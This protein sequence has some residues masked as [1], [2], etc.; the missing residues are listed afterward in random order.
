MRSL[1]FAELKDDSDYTYYG[2]DVI[3]YLCLNAFSMEWEQCGVFTDSVYAYACESRHDSAQGPSYRRLLASPKITKVSPSHGLPGTVLTVSGQY[4]D[5]GLSMN[6]GASVNRSSGDLATSLEVTLGG[7]PCSVASANS[8][9]FTCRLTALSGSSTPISGNPRGSGVVPVRVS[10]KGFGWAGPSLLPLFTVQHQLFNVTPAAGSLGGGQNITIRGVNLP[11]NL[12][13]FEVALTVTANHTNGTQLRRSS[14]CAALVAAQDGTKVVCTTSAL[15]AD[16]MLAYGESEDLLKRY[17]LGHGRNASFDNQ[18]TYEASLDLGV[19]L[20]MDGDLLRCSY[21][22]LFRAC[23]Y[24]CEM[25]SLHT[26][27][28]VHQHQMHVTPLNCF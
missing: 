13:R 14:P 7:A 9:Q 20:T 8:T 11:S 15:S 1:L 27:G 3:A 18:L 16:V 23:T 12:A 2:N 22:L 17:A 19:K 24:V 4:L 25:A 21:F 5:A 10:A 28:R 6:A 26:C